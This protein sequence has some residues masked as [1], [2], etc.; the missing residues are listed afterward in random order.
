LLD[1]SNKA[2]VGAINPDSTQARKRSFVPLGYSVERDGFRIWKIIFDNESE[3]PPTLIAQPTWI[4]S[5]E[6]MPKSNAQ[7]S[8]AVRK[9][10]MKNCT[11]YLGYKH[12]KGFYDPDST[13]SDVFAQYDS[14]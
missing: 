10:T 5:P 7:V 6:D 1:S 13:H 3:E 8:V 14:N 9:C 4:S 2:K 11:I 12:F